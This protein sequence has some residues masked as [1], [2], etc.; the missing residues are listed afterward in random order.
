MK[1]IK[2]IILVAVLL[3]AQLVQAQ[4][5]IAMYD[6]T[7]VY[8]EALSLFDHEK[9]SASKEKFEEYVL[10]ETDKK[11]A[12]RINAEYYKG[13]CALYLM[14]RDAE[15]EL[16][17]FVREH[18]DSPWKGHAY[19]E[20]A[21]FNYK[22]K[23]YKKAIEWFK[24]VDASELSETQKI[25]FYYKRGHSL[26]ETNDS[27]TARQDFFEVMSVE[28]QYKQAATYYY[29]HIAYEQGDLQTALDGFKKLESD[30]N[31]SPVVPYYI[32]Q[33]YY[34]QKKYDELLAYAPAVLQAAKDNTT[35]RVPEIARLI[36][37]AYF[38][39]EKYSEAIPYLEQFHT[40]VEKADITREDYYELGYA[41]YRTGNYTKALEAFSGCSGENDELY[42]L[43]TY[44]MA[45][46]Y[47]KLDKKEYARNAFGEAAGME[48]N[49]EIQEDALFNYSKLAFELSYNPFHEAI[50]AFEDY[51][52][53]YPDSPRRDEAYEFL[54]NVYMKTR[55]YEKALASLDKIKN[56]DNRVK[57]AY[58]VVAYNRGVELFQAEDFANSEKFFDKVP[59]YTV[60]PILNSDAKFWKAEIS[61]R[62]KDFSKAITRYSA[63]LSEQ[64]SINSE[65][66]GLANYG[67]GYCYFKLANEENNMNTMRDLYSN[68]NTG[69]RKYA[70]GNGVKDAK[71]VNDANLRIGDCFYVNKSYVQAIQYY[72]KVADN[73]QGNKDYAMFQ[74]AMCYGFD[75]KNDKKAWVLKSLLSEIPDSKFK[76]DAKYELAST[77]LA[78]DR[79][80]EAKTYYSD[81]LENHSTSAYNK[82]ALTDMCLVYVKENNYNKVKE[83]WNTLYQQYPNDPILKDAVATVQSTLIEDT[84]FQNQI[85]S[86]KIIDIKDSDI[87]KQVYD[88][89]ILFAY[90]GDCDKAIEKLSSYLQQFQPA[91][92]GAEAHYYLA[93]CYFDRN[94]MDKALNSY[95]YVI[96]ESF[97]DYTEDALKVAA[98]INYNKKNYQLA[99]DHYVDLEQIAVQKLNVLEAQIGLMRCYYFL[100]R[101]D[102]AAIYA[103]KVIINSSTPEDIR[104]TGFL[105]RGR[106]RM[107]NMDDAGATT[108][109]KE[110][111]KKGGVNAAEAKYNIAFMFNRAGEYKKAE[112][113]LFQH[114]EKYSSFT[115][116]KYKA[117][118]L[119][120]DV[121]VGMKDYFQARATLNAIL[122]KVEEQWVRDEATRKLSELDAIENPASSGGSRST[123]E[124]IN[125]VPEEGSNN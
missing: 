99:A 71:K 93:N 102:Q 4:R 31:F 28:S 19:F 94:E 33:I 90:Q 27:K 5:P 121:Y 115:E 56:K 23:N 17:R 3:V 75:G 20:L 123:E 29:S 83:T 73:S 58:Q 64:G 38:I 97:N 120:S 105:W 125:L 2:S 35:K 48:F 8:N 104:T 116:W 107:D 67:L 101:K 98:T 74:K 69:F 9:Y 18:P 82:R 85:R 46:C 68:A 92:F 62:Q 6:K 65:F 112:T 49:R 109:F 36:G 95:N 26:F 80:A 11:N 72:D 42:Q 77:Y 78:D 30:P 32:T 88:K 45:D 103:D 55:N 44:N 89:A 14:H 79:L 86:I 25:E 117:F 113:E 7:A 1:S 96:N 110:V 10:L 70:D 41:Y 43:A 84:E 114:I 54:L 119:L 34:K 87:E 81:I 122:D 66:Y 47:L 12:L 106:I 59:T 124:E 37:D 50:T 39:K 52:D 91:T 60:N 57:E 22:S 24:E 13:I 21:S 76:V 100:D 16:E 108:D 118:L 63:F 61:Y 53:K 15:F 40:G 51:L 111:I